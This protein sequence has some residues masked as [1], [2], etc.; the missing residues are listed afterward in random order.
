MEEIIT[1][2]CKII[3]V[4]NWK[5]GVG[6]TTLAHHL[7]VGMQH[8]KHEEIEAYFGTKGAPRILLIDADAQCNLSTVCLGEDVFEEKVIKKKG[9]TLNDLIGAFLIDENQNLDVREF[10]LKKSVRSDIDKK[11]TNVDLI[12][13]H[14]DLIFTDMNIAVYSKPDFKNN[15]VNSSMYK[16]QIIN[17]I[18]KKVKEDY[19]L[20][21]IDCPPNL[22]YIT[23]NALFASDYY[24]IPTI[25]D[26][27]SCYGI[28]SIYKKVNHLNRLLKQSCAGYVETKLIGVVINCVKEYN[29]EPKGTQITAINTLKKSFGDKVF[30]NYLN[31]GDG[32]PKAYELS[33]P[34]FQLEKLRTVAAKQCKQIRNI[35]KEFLLRI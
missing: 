4:L 20:I 11:Y 12:S 29:N 16:F 18:I 26:R 24:L 1:G 27:L 32:I 8:M 6:K 30:E 34:V 3:S 19:D 33:Y 2:S 7:A 28:P 15:L 9:N 22:Y 13:S 14:P 31:A 17:N 21:F 35:I 25:P 23:Q 10:I 5:G